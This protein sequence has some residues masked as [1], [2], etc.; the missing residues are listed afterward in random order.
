MSFLFGSK[1]Q[2]SPAEQVR[3]WQSALRNEQRKIEREIRQ[4]KTQE[5][6]LMRTAK[7]AARKT[8]GDKPTLQ[9]YA[10]SIAHAR[11]HTS[12]LYSTRAT[13]LSTSNQLQNM[14]ATV[15]MAGTLQRSTQV[16]SSMQQLIKVPQIAQVMQQVAMEMEKAGIIEEMVGEAVDDAMNVDEEAEAEEHVQDVLDEILNQKS[17]AQQ[18][19]EIRAKQRKAL[20]EAM[21]AE[22]EESEE[23]ESSEEEAT[24]K[25]LRGR[26]SA[27]KS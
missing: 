24:E 12:R 22:S 11:A 7:E 4:M 8:N 15:K 18:Q 13:I 5:D 27:L 2:P 26:L 17:V 6:K 1:P 3:G 14:L 25:A 19:A 21:A 23:Q 16:I 10:S 20:E 9:T